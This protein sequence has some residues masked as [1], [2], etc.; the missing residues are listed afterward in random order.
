LRFIGSVVVLP[1]ETLSSIAYTL[2]PFF[3]TGS[4]FDKRSVRDAALAG[5]E[6]EFGKMSGEGAEQILEQTRPG[7]LLAELRMVF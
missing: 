6:S 2:A 1:P 4:N 3:G 7:E 5:D